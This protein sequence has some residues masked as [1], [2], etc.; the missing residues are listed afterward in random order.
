M[1]S[2][3]AVRYDVNAYPIC[4]S[5]LERSPRRSF[6][7][8]R[9]SRCHNRSYVWIY[10]VKYEH[11]SDMWLSTLEIVAAQLPSVTEIA[12]P[13]PF[14]CVNTSSIR[15]MVFVA[16]Q[17]LSVSF[18][19]TTPRTKAY[20]FSDFVTSASCVSDAWKSPKTQ[21]NSR[22]ASRFR[23]RSIDRSEHVYLWQILRMLFNDAYFF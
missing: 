16:A 22:H 12:P 18:W 19:A 17:K 3:K 6:A 21:N 1:G 8:S 20:W 7:P 2:R 10:T 15:F 13:K 14:L 11:L 9:K 5:S 23:Q 4:E